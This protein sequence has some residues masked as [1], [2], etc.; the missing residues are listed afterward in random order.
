MLRGRRLMGFLFLA[1]VAFPLVGLDLFGQDKDKKSEDKKEDAKKTE[2]KKDDTKKADT[3]KDDGKKEAPKD[4]SKA[5]LAWKFEKGKTFYQKMVTDTTQKMTVMNNDVTQNQKQTFFFEWKVDDVNDKENKVTLEQK[6]LGVQMDID[7]GGSPIKYDSTAP[8][9]NNT[10]NPLSEFFKA[11]VGATFKVTL[12][13]KTLKITNIEGRQKFVDGLV[14]ANKQMKPLLDKILS[15]EALKEMAEPTFAVVT[16][17]TVEKG[18]T[19]KRETKLDMGPIGSYKNE[20]TYKYE[21]TDDK[22][23]LDK[24]DVDTK[25]TYTP[26]EKTDGIGGLPFKIKSA[27]LTSKNAKGTIY[28]NRDKGRVDKTDMSL[29][30]DG[31]LQ[32][33]IGGQPTEVKLNQTQKTTVDTSDTNPVE[34]KP[35]K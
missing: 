20:Y 22:T 35:A 8:A 26:P 5:T 6:I 3:K 21:G 1:V 31:K 24:I 18:K 32:I 19:W 28:F 11:L 30:L 17:G 15:E 27:D 4:P 2:T 7:I 25:L 29:E 14:A 10:S 23:K 16:D 9:A 34:A 12:D 33:E 13:T